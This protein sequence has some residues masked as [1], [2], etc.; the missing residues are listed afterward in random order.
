MPLTHLSIANAKPR[1]LEYKLTD[2][3]ALYLAVRPNGA[4]LW[5]MNYRYLGRQKTLHFGAWPEIGIAAARAHRDAAR[6]QLAS[7]LDPASEKKRARVAET[8]AAS[9]SFKAVAE[10]WLVKNEKEGRA[11]IT[12][13]KIRW[14]L[15]IAYPMIGSLPISKITAQEALA[16]LRKM[17]GNGRYESARRMRSVLSRVFRYGIATAR[18][19]RDVARDLRGALITPKV[20]HLAAITTP[21][22]AGALMR[23]IDG[24]SGHEVTAMALKISPHVFLRPGELRKAEW[25]EID[26]QA[27]LWSLPADKMKMRRPHRVPLSHQVLALLEDLHALTGHGRFLFPSSR[28]PRHPMSENTVNAALRRLGFKQDEMTAHGFRAMAATL[29]NEMGIW[30]PDAIE[31]QLAHLDGSMVR[32]AYTRGEYWEERVRMMQHWS[33]YIDK[34]RGGAKI[35]AG[36][37]PANQNATAI[38]IGKLDL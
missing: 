2:S 7:D 27:A 21:R 31:K 3:D 15:R 14:L 13:E 6:R 38:F 29:L 1:A 33:D 24:Y 11:P 20:T 10:E 18:A 22:E 9:N 8:V 30:N 16:V 32:R 12:L 23:T 37:F 35:I 4:K 28:S 5:R 36:R 26:I 19:D 34:L 17:E 25:E